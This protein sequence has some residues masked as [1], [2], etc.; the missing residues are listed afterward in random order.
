[1]I[2]NVCSAMKTI[3]KSFALLA[4]AASAFVSC[5]GE[6]TTP[7][8]KPQTGKFEYTFTLGAPETKAVL[9][10]DKDE[11][12]KDIYFAKW[13]EGDQLGVYT[14]SDA[15]ITNNT[16]ADID[17]EEEHV[18]F[19]VVTSYALDESSEVYAYFPYDANN[20]TEAEEDPSAVVLS[21]PASQT[22][23][24]N[25]MPMAAKPY[26]VT[27]TIPVGTKP[28]ADIKMRN[29]GSILNFNVFSSVEAY[30]SETV[31]SIAFTTETPLCGSFT[32]DIMEAELADITGYE[33]TTVTVTKNITPGNDRNSG[34]TVPMVVAPNATDGYTGTIVV[35]TN[36]ATYTYTISSPIKIDRSI[37]KKV[38]VDL[39]SS[40]AV[41]ELIAPEPPAPT[42]ATYTLTFTKL[43]SS[44]TNYNT[45]TAAHDYTCDNI[46]WSIY[47]NQSMDGDILRIGGKNTTAT[48]RTITSTDKIPGEVSYIVINHNGLGNGSK[49]EITVNSFSI[50]ASTTS[51]F[52]DET[53][54]K[55]TTTDLSLNDA[56]ELVL[57]FENSHEDCYYRITMNY[58]VTITSGTSANN[59]YLTVNN[60]EFWLGAVAS[61]YDVTVSDAIVGGSVT[62]SKAKAKEGEE[63]TLVPIANAGYDFTSW[64]VT[65]GSNPVS[66]TDNK[67]IMPAGDVTVSATF[68]A[69]PTYSITLTQ[70]AV[71]GTISSD[72]ATAWEG[73]EV[74]L[75]YEQTEEQAEK[76]AFKSWT[77]KYG[78]SNTPIAV[79][80]NKF[81]M[82]ASTV[83]ATATFIPTLTVSPMNPTK[84]ESPAGSWN[85][86]VTTV[87]TDWEV[88]VPNDQDWASVEKTNNGFTL[89][90]TANELDTESTEDRSVEITV[91]S[92]QAEKTGESAI[93]ITFTQSGKEYIAPGTGY[94]LVTDASDLSAGMVIVLGC[95]EKSKV[96]GALGGNAYLSDQDANITEGVLTSNN[97]IEFTLGGSSA[98]WTL[99]SEEGQLGATAAK[100]MSSDPSVDNYVGIWTITIDG[101]GNASITSTTSGYGTI[102]YNAS[103]PRFLNYASGQT[104]IQIYA[105][106]D[107]LENRNLAFT[108]NSD[109]K[110]IKDGTSVSVLGLNGVTDGTKTYKS[111]DETIATIAN[112]GTITLLKEG[113]TTISV[114]IAKNETYRA[115]S[116]SYELTVNDTR[117]ACATP[118]ASPVA[119]KVDKNTT[120]T[121]SC[122][123]PNAKIYYRIGTTG[124]FTQY[125]S[126]IT[127]DAAKTIYAYAEAPGYKRS[128][129][130][131]FA[132]TIN[133]GGTMEINFEGTISTTDWTTNSISSGQTTITAHSGSKHGQIASTSGYIQTKNKINNPISFVCYVSK[134]TNNTT[135]ST[136]KVQY[137]AN[138][139]NWTDVKEQSAT[140]MSKGTW[141]EINTE[142]T[143][144][145]GE[146]YV[147]IYYSGSNAVRCIDDLVITY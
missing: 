110:D 79:S 87:A 58:K 43:T 8:E 127:I 12:N 124:D 61:K 118:T 34:N 15:G 22:G 75:A 95:A 116:A 135:S 49:T 24:L 33:G 25:A 144:N 105:K 64:N 146:V 86:T 120:V 1:M 26:S 119:G 123:T 31:S 143:K 96:A 82:P 41:R 92:E 28:I 65:C 20:S 98:A 104:D 115:G 21:I 59:C 147:R 106:D 17:L 101:D 122:T 128:N 47:G 134:S 77:V 109:I 99:T 69:K 89:T 90:Y 54:E 29:L 111:S 42:E 132:Y 3:V 23:S 72:P 94:N 126:A 11:S 37:I 30:R 6:L 39:G 38:N 55:V 67:F 103:S 108:A 45:Y 35:T 36:V 60:I 9:D 130:A 52:T 7:E 76:Y 16:A 48:D 78:P 10:S 44:V 81:E 5:K 88:S 141:V 14:L 113:T 73:Q 107:G 121:L 2:F 117:E 66:V 83:S 138:G 85:F 4:V 93:K 27:E 62:A 46:G 63:V 131:S 140:S 40:N 70:P 74:T 112:D 18:K 53:T 80:N 19:K 13:E 51:T 139:T 133:G 97:A 56:G 84:K 136:W 129:T 142:F 100:K 137:S 91:S 50:E 71:G 68:T 57:N 125:S 102:K 145:L 32:Y 114:S